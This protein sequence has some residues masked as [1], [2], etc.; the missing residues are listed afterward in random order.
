MGFCSLFRMIEGSMVYSTG[1]RELWSVTS[2]WDVVVLVMWESESAILLRTCVD[3]RCISAVAE[4]QLQKIAS[5]EEI[6]GKA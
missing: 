6:P 1:K 4:E 2:F 5:D 3:D